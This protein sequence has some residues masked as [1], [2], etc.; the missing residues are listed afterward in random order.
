MSRIFWKELSDMRFPIKAFTFA[1]ILIG[2]TLAAKA[3]TLDF[4]LTGGGN[5][6]IF[7]L[8]SNPTP[9]SSTVG[10]NFILDNILV[11]QDPGTPGSIAFSTDLTF[12]NAT[13]GGGIGF[14]LPSLPPTMLELLLVGPQLYTGLETAPMF[15]PTSTPFSLSEPK[16]TDDFTLA[17]AS[18]VP[19][20]SSIAL[21]ATG[22]F[23]FAATARRKL[24]VH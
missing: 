16:G 2:A 14:P 24:L 8:P 6:F 12:S 7:S 13:A 15:S 22:L 17:I 1:V 9:D 23:A 3:D 19:E 5:T 4:T 10:T 11:T 20:P 21:L 18:E